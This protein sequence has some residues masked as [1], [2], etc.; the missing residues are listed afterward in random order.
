MRKTQVQTSIS[1]EGSLLFHIT[2]LW[3]GQGV[4]IS[5]SSASWLRRQAPRYDTSCLISCPHVY[6][7]SLY[8]SV[9]AAGNSWACQGCPCCLW[10]C[11]TWGCTVSLSPPDS[12]SL[13]RLALG[14]YH[15][16][17]G[18]FLLPFWLDQCL[19]QHSASPG[20]ALPNFIGVFDFSYVCLL[21]PWVCG[22]PLYPTLKD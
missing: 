5:L 19:P 1:K 9:H 16:L 15:L 22:P 12:F 3:D 8:S 18:T 20:A 10:T 7:C 2:K 13:E 11:W 21:F 14:N 17:E 6:L 4:W